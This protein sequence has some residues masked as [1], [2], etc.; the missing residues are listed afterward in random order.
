MPINAELEKFKRTDSHKCSLKRKGEKVPSI[1][2]C[3]YHV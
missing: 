1:S 3:M 2:A